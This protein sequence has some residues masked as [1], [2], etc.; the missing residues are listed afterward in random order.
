VVAFSRI[1]VDR[2][3]LVVANTGGGSFVGRVVL[4][5]DVNPAGRVVR[6]AY[7][8]RGTSGTATVAAIPAARFHRDGQVTTGQAAA[9][10]VTLR[11]SEVQVFVPA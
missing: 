9:L 5:L 1:L 10:G 7:S 8:N 11:A 2:E 4:D 3:V 6:I